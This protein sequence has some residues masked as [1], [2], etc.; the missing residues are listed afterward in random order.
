MKLA[1]ITKNDE[2]SKNCAEYIISTG[3]FDIVNLN[4][5]LNNVDFIISIGGDGTILKCVPYAMKFNAPIL[6]LNTGNVGFLSAYS[7]N[8][9]TQLMDDL[10]NNSFIVQ[11]RTILEVKLKN[12]KLYAL[13]EI[14]VERSHQNCQI[15]LFDFSIDGEEDISYSSDGCLIATPTGS[16]G[17][18]YSAGGAI[19]HP[20]CNVLIAT[21]ICPRGTKA[22]SIVYPNNKPAKIT[23]KKSAMPCNAYID[24]I[25]CAEMMEGDFLTVKSSRKKLKIVKTKDFFALLN[26]KIN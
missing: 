2:T 20:D 17:Y 23:V 22:N 5:A 16:T 7:K 24:G 12:K 25:K 26:Q 18:S 6:S 15:A 4:S 21:A 14:V 10:K 9:I 11:D 19:L 8:Q 13:N 1:I 3:L